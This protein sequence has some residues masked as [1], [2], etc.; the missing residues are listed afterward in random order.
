RGGR[1]LRSDPNR[2]RLFFSPTAR[3]LSS[4]EGYVAVYELFFPV[5]AVGVADVATLAA[6]VSLLPGSP[7]QLIYAAPKIT[8]FDRG[9]T[10]IAF[11]GFAASLTGTSGTGG[12]VFGVATQGTSVASVTGGVGFL[13]GDGDF[14]ETPIILL[15]GEY[16]LSKSTKFLTEN[17]IIPAA[18]SAVVISGGIRFFGESLSADFGLFTSPEVIGEGGFPFLPWLGFAYQFG[19]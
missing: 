14:V 5:V 10:S 9:S 13:F 17:Y 3:S 4:G 1:I 15:G 16:Q 19:R 7:E 8:V 18:E 6:G 2:T 11:G 12:I